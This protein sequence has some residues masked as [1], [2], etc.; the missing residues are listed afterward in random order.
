M[1]MKLTQDTEVETYLTCLIPRSVV[2]C[3]L[4][5]L[6]NGQKRISFPMQLRKHSGI[7][8]SGGFQDALGCLLQHLFNSGTRF[9]SYRSRS[10]TQ[11]RRFGADLSIFD[12]KRGFDDSSRRRNFKTRRNNV[13]Q[14]D[15]RRRNDFRHFVRRRFEF[16]NGHAVLSKK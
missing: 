14:F 7:A 2:Q 13:R 4:S 9:R 1:L 8:E 10:C 12:I 16:F 11:I 3:S 15:R 5:G 6:V